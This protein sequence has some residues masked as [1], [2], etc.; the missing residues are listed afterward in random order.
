MYVLREAGETSSLSS[1]QSL[2]GATPTSTPTQSEQALSVY[3]KQVR[4]CQLAP[5]RTEERPMPDKARHR[6]TP[7]P[8][9]RS[10]ASISVALQ[11]K[12]WTASNDSS[13]C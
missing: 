3:A 9:W 7:L 12:F 8:W 1:L 6:S 5:D 4:Q 11:L 13:S 2:R 10:M